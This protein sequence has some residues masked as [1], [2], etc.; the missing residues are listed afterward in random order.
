MMYLE[1]TEETILDELGMYWNTQQKN[2]NNLHNFFA[3]D[4]KFP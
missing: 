3:L 4:L 1:L 2:Q